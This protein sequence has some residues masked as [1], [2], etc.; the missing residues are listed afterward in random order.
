M[1]K[2]NPF[3]TA[4]V[5]SLV[6]FIVFLMLKYFLQQRIIDM[7]G[8]LVGAIVFW[9]VIFVVHQFLRRRYPE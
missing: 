2:K 3:F 4:S 1:D 8:A 5:A 6:Y 9:I 7:Q